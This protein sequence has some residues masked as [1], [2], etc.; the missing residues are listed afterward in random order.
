LPHAPQLATS[1][2][3]F[4]HVPAQS[5]R[6]VWHVS[7]HAPAEQMSPAGHAIPHTPQLPLSVVRST[8]LPLQFVLPV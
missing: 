8:Q 6:P 3:V 2:F 5:V 1:V 7:A 4:V